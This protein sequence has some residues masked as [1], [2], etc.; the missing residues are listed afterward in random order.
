VAL[1]LSAFLAPYV[2]KM[3]KFGCPR[4]LGSLCVVGF[5]FLLFLLCLAV[6]SFFVK[7]YISQYYKNAHNTVAL[8]ADWIPRRINHLAHSFHIPVEIDAAMIRDFLGK[9]LGE[10][11]EAIVHSLLA[12]Y[13]RAKSVASAVSFVIFV[14]ILTVYLTKDWPKGVRK[15]REYTPR[16]LLA[17]FDFAFQRA[18][19][20]FKKQWKGQC[21]VSSCVCLFYAVGLFFIGIKPFILLGILSGLLTFIPFLGIFIAFLLAFLMGLGQGVGPLSLVSIIALY[22]LGS[23]IESNVLT[24]RWVGAEIGLHPV[25]VF[26]AVLIIIAWL[27][28]GA[29]F[30]VMPLATLMWSLIQS[31]IL[32]LKKEEQT[33]NEH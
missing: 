9:S 7:K 17:F 33:G 5:F 11:S 16:K 31:A 20:N 6:F 15:V 2:S 21:A 28:F 12:L 13:D 30:F 1:I 18:K 10:L 26:F 29:A 8:L 3:Q 32:W 22:F 19:I 23:S 25:W 14:P 24:P 4:G 27:G